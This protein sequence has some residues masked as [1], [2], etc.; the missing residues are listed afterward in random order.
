VTISLDRG[1][2]LPEIV[3]PPPGPRSRALAEDLARLEAPAA[4]TLFR[5]EPSIVWRE[6]LGANVLD[7][8]GNRYIDLT[9]G[10]GVAA[11]GHRHPTVQRAIES[12]AGRLVHGMADVAAHPERIHLAGRLVELAP[13]ADAQVYFAISGGDAVEIALKTAWLSTGRS[14]TVVFDPAYHGTTLGALA[15]T[16]RPAFREPFRAQLNPH[17]FRLPYGAPMADLAPAITEE[18]AAVLVEPVVGREGIIVP[19]AGWMAELAALCSERGAL[20][21]ADEIYTG[22]GRTGYLFACE[23]SG[24]EPDLLC[25]GKALGGGLPIAA[26]L[27]RRELFQVWERGGEAIH[28]ATFMANPIACAAAL[29]SLDVIETEGLVERARELG[30]AMEDRTS[31]WTA[32]GLVERVAGRGLAWSLELR[33]TDVAGALARAAARRGLLMLSSGR[34]CQLAPP[35]VITQTQWGFALDLVEELAGT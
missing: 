3:A 34:R 13:M 21:I 16:S 18:V 15:A 27:G 28:T 4:N 23:S 5:G 11:V 26:V 7:V 20:L 22:F 35:L 8:D 32:A 6:A 29:A 25:C 1:D 17:L 33:S 12:Q 31:R 9:A 10:F 14:D 19:P 30:R 24:V 2:Q